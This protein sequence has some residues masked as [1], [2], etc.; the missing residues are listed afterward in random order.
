MSWGGSNG[1]SS[2]QDL[3]VVVKNVFYKIQTDHMMKDCIKIS[4]ILH[5]SDT[6]RVFTEK[7]ADSSLI[8]LINPRF[9]GNDFEK[10]L[11]EGFN[12]L[13][14]TITKYDNFRIIFMSDGGDSI[15][16]NAMKRINESEV[17][18]NN[19]LSFNLIM[20]GNDT[21]GI[22]TMKEISRVLNTPFSQ[23]ANL[24]DLQKSFNSL[25]YFYIFSK[26][27]YLNF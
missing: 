22:S 7:T 25:F 2:W 8:N 20:Q 11:S 21:Y 24:D 4:V 17:R 15:P 16:Y 3:M 23:A 18:K 14:E 13:N 27:S 26:C 6:M 12:L 5:E 10:A 9:G 19:R 1:A